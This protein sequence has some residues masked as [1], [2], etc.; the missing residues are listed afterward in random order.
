MLFTYL[1]LNN[2]SYLLLEPQLIDHDQRPFMGAL[3]REGRR[4]ERYT[5][6]TIIFPDL[7]FIHF[8]Y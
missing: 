5:G 3:P 1:I 2:E 8:I 6:H 7:F 4:R